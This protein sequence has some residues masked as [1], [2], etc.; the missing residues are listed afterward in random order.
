MLLVDNM[1]VD[2]IVIGAGFGL[3]WTLTEWCFIFIRKMIR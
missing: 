1:F 3:G 2:S